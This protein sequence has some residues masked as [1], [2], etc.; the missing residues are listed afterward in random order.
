MFLKASKALSDLVTEEQRK[1]NMLLPDLN[2]IRNVSYRVALAVAI[3]ARDSG[4]GRLLSDEEY[5]H[6]IKKAQ[7]EPH[8]YPYRPHD[9]D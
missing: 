3:E 8:Y 1:Q 9:G 5:A 6:V 4:L 7:W 2:D